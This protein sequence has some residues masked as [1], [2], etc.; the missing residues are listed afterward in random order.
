MHQPK[1]YRC[2]VCGAEV[3]DQ[4]IVALKHQLSHVQR[5]GRAVDRAADP[6]APATDDQQP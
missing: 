3:L 4:L 6:D 5:R 1:P 2:T